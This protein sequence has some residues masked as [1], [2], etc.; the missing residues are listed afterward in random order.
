MPYFPPT[1]AVAHVIRVWR[2]IL[3]EHRQSLL[4]FQ[5][6]HKHPAPA[7]ASSINLPELL[8]KMAMNE[9]CWR[10]QSISLKAPVAG[11]QEALPWHCPS[12]RV[13]KGI[14]FLPNAWIAFLPTWAAVPR[15]SCSFLNLGG[16]WTWIGQW[17]VRHCLVYKIFI[18]IYITPLKNGLNCGGPWAYQGHVLE[19]YTIGSRH[20]PLVRVRRKEWLEQLCRLS[21]SM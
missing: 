11:S 19:G 5:V 15:H 7:Q 3:L 4:F 18:K 1:S 16:S 9:E 20:S 13:R 12:N 8:I 2:L 6:S 17:A 14:V 21:Y 10:L